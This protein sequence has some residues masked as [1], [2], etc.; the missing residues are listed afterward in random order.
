MII[1]MMRILFLIVN[2]SVSVDI[3]LFEMSIWKV[4]MEYFI[5]IIIVSFW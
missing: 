1:E 3:G 4:L 2:L 5:G